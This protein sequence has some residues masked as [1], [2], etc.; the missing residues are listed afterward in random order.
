M[1]GRK[2]EH[3]NIYW[4][5]LF[6]GM[7]LGA[8]TTALLVLNGRIAGVSGIVGRLLAG[9]QIQ[10]NAAFV[11]GLL[12]GPPLYALT[13]G[14]L[15]TVTIAA[16]WPLVLVAGFLVGI[17]T[18]MGSGC[19]SGHGICGLAR[20]SKRSFTATATFL[21]AGVATATLAEFLS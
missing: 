1:F 5:S 18:R 16:S 21:I 10:L 20:F 7:M 15:P 9:G 11:V 4:T 2:A 6:G 13:F 19:T 12:C 3:M 14:I 8:S 17:G